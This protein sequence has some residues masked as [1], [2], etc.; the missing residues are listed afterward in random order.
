[1]KLTGQK[2]I[3]K[4]LHS[5]FCQTRNEDGIILKFPRPN[6]EVL[7][8]GGA[9]KLTPTDCTGITKPLIFTVPYHVVV[10]QFILSTSEQFIYLVHIKLFEI[11][12]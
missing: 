11:L 2:P 10:F 8:P 6:F 1:M 12:K 4:E 7:N 3:L 5:Y 9:G